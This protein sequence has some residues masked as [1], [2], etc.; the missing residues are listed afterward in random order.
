MVQHANDP[1]DDGTTQHGWDHVVDIDG[2]DSPS[3]E[4]DKHDPAERP[5]YKSGKLLP[6]QPSGKRP[7]WTGKPM[8]ALAREIVSKGRRFEPAMTPAATMA[9]PVNS[10]APGTLDVAHWIRPLE[11]FL[12]DWTRKQLCRINAPGRNRRRVETADTV[13][14]KLW[15]T[16]FDPAS[17]PRKA[18]MSMQVRCQVL[19]VPPNKL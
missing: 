9:N 15:R 4:S 18:V 19:E 13:D 2:F 16:C 6:A 17:A 14:A 7:W 11:G 12:S 5:P 1:A 8:L 10:V 3:Q